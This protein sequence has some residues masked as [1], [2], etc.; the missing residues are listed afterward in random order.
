M[1]SFLLMPGTTHAGF[2]VDP[3]LQGQQRRQPDL[4]VLQGCVK[5]DVT[6]SDLGGKRVADISTKGL[7]ENQLRKVDPSEDGDNRNMMGSN[8]TM[9]KVMR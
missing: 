1:H 5:T 3:C 2:T 9:F 8:S 7:S 4:W 6:K